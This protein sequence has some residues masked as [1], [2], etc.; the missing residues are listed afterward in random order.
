MNKIRMNISIA[1]LTALVFMQ[2]NC[3]AAGW[4]FQLLNSF[5]FTKSNLTLENLDHRRDYRGTAVTT[6]WTANRK[7][8]TFLLT[9]E[10]IWQ[11]PDCPVYLLAAGSYGWVFDGHVKRDPLKWE[12]NGTEK[13]FV[14]EAGYIMDVCKRF[15][16]L[17]HI[18]FYWD[19]T[20]I[21]LSDQKETRPNPT[22]YISH[23][24]DRISNLIYT[25][26]I[27]FQL[28]FATELWNCEKIQI[29]TLYDIGYWGSGHAKTRVRHTVIN[30]TGASSRYGNRIKYEDMFYQNW[31]VAL[32]YNF[33]KYWRGAVEFNY[34][35]FYNTHKLPVKLSRNRD[36]VR[37][38][39]FTRSQFHVASE[40]VSRTYSI[41]F[42]INYS[43]GGTEGV[44]I[45]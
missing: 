5:N 14:L 27:G 33:T 19:R 24:G 9:P 11:S 16:F 40:A 37:Q 29:S 30:D 26:Y 35:S 25:P 32:A 36:I 39:Q 42:L 21:R 1:M 41:V 17:P 23:N 22:C 43:F 31:L 38:G 34:Y 12:V 18:G 20:D 10:V 15:S 13:G 4:S 6:D 3:S 8:T 7:F 45:R 44:F 28:D 2:T